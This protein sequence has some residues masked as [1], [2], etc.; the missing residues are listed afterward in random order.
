MLIHL[1]Q[2]T[3]DETTH[4]TGSGPAN[5]GGYGP[6][7]DLIARC[8]E[9]DVLKRRHL[10]RAAQLLRG[11][12]RSGI[13]EVVHTPPGGARL[14]VVASLQ[15]DFSMHRS[16]S[17]YL[18][19]ALGALDPEHPDHAL[20]VLSLVESILDN[21]RAI[22]IAQEKEAKSLRIAELKAAGVPY[23][24]RLRE[25]EDITYPKPKAEFIY[26]TFR[27][28][29]EHHPWV[30]EEHIRPK[31]IAREML[32]SYASFHDTVK[33][34]GIARSEGLLLRYLG[35]AYT[36]LARTVPEESRTEA[37]EDALAF[38]RTMLERVDASL[39]EEWES[40]RSFAPLDDGFSEEAAAAPKPYDLAEH[41]R[42]L[43]ARIRAELHALVHA[44]ARG[45]FEEAVACVRHDPSDLWDEARFERELAPFL[46]E[47]ARIV[48]D[49]SARTPQRTRVLK[50]TP[51]VFEVAQVLVD[52]EDENDWCLEGEIEV[53]VGQPPDGP[54]LRLRRIGT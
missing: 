27:V 35:D 28:F 38:F 7:R 3:T 16:L 42:A 48:F 36:T 24:D 41:P 11:L 20:D 39:I 17:L 22:L 51:R 54:L 19:D 37:L 23:E 44:L 29:C 33:R 53:P 40:R 1:L 49:P 26:A 43:A 50:Q 25:L 6:L 21:P 45:D 31:S 47:H 18:V 9:S 13:V 34:Y 2:R 30:G 32:E 8:H 46:A 12:R 52:P 10:R 15:R 14:R 4:A 5:G